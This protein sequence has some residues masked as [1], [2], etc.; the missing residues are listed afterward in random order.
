MKSWKTRKEKKEVERGFKKEE[1]P[2]LRELIGL[3]ERPSG[4]L[5]QCG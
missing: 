5:V 1:P 3:N 4:Y 2:T